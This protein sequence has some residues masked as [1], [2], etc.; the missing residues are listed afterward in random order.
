M[1]ALCTPPETV[2]VYSE[3]TFGRAGEE[4]SSKMIPFLRFDAPSRV[5]MPKVPSDETLTSFRKRASNAVE[6]TFTGVA[7]FVTSYTQS[8][9][10]ITDVAYRYVPNTHC[11]IV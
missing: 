6:S 4:V 7:G 5:T 9:P 2:S 1:N 11:S 3:W 8:F 10:A